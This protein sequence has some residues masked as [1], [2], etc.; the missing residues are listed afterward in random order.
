MIVGTEIELDFSVLEDLDFPI[1]CEVE[2]HNDAAEWAYYPSCGCVYLVCG[3]AHAYFQA[4]HLPEHRYR[5][6]RCGAR[7]VRMMGWKPL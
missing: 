7:R 3:E 4:G 6:M 2:D 1:P 5:C